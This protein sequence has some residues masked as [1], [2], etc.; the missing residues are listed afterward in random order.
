MIAPLLLVWL[1]PLP[2]T[3]QTLPALLQAT[4]DADPAIAGA[5]AQVR[6]AEQRVTQARASFGPTAALTANSTESRYTE[7]PAFDLRQFRSLQ[8]AVQVTQPLYRGTLFPALD[9]AQALLS[10]AQAGLAQAQAESAQ[11]LLEAVFELLKSR[12]ALSFSRAQQVASAEQ[13]AAARRAFEVGT[14][15]A[16]DLRESEARAD[17]VA[18]QV[19]T[20]ESD[21]AL[22][23]Q[24]LAELAGQAAPGLME[25]GL[26]GSQLPTL[27]VASVLE[28]LADANINN[29]QVAQALRALEA[30]E[31]EVRKAWLGHAP[32]ADMSLSYT[33]SGDT[34]TV[35]SAFPRRGDT[36]AI[37]FNV[38]V[39]LFAS[40]ATQARV[41]EALA[42]RD[43]AQADVASA[44][45]TVSL[46]V[47]QA[48]SATLSAIAQARAL[49]AA[50]RS[51][52]LAFRANRRAY[53]V[54]TKANFEVLESQSKL[55]EAR[56]DL[57]RAR[58]DA[59]SGYL[60]LKTQAGLPVNTDITALDGWM[61]SAP[62]LDLLTP[63]RPAAGTR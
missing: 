37:A 18:A 20:T 52:E 9:A 61:V 1:L 33:M 48:F 12:D 15:A 38:N 55:F 29:P 31:A 22:R 34:G 56:R 43:K 6:A 57:S 24:V 62:P 19:L 46:A 13:L 49:T 8:M 51:Q 45:R 35:T 40:G 14:V 16:T 54:G 25:R 2:G 47:R 5:S 10:Q 28:W 36:S 32:T 23:Q 17:A 44:R 41:R 42:Q 4:L 53:Q 60:K 21:L 7:A 3:A 30:A 27:A 63:V 58:Y 59:W 11:R 26:D 50:V 39:P